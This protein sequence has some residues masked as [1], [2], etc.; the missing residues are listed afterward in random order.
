MYATVMFVV[1]LFYLIGNAAYHIYKRNFLRGVVYAALYVLIFWLFKEGTYALLINNQI[2]D[3]SEAVVC[4][5]DRVIKLLITFYLA[6]TALLILF[7]RCNCSSSTF[8]CSYF[9][10]SIVKLSFVLYN[11]T[12]LLVMGAISIAE[13]LFN[14]VIGSVAYKQPSKCIYHLTPY[15]AEFKKGGWFGMILF[16]CSFGLSIISIIY[17]CIL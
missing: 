4:G 17:I 3:V 11:T 10:L 13:L 8:L 7:I 15:F 12:S 9:L 6:I 14:P 16:L 2:S 5:F 1:L